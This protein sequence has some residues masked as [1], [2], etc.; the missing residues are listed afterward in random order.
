MTAQ[1]ATFPYPPF[2]HHPNFRGASEAATVLL[3]HLLPDHLSP[4]QSA[5][6]YPDYVLKPVRKG[7]LEAGINVIVPDKYGK[8]YRYLVAGQVKASRG[9]S[10]S[11]A[12]KEGAQ[13]MTLPNLDFVFSA[14]VALAADGRSLS[15]GYGF[16]VDKEPVDK[17]VD[18]LPR[19]TL[20][21]PLQIVELGDYDARVNLYATPEGVVIP[22]Q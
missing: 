3:E 18:K 6:C 13:L 1:V 12:Q 11:G 10:I 20:V 14:C 9:S 7:L 16:S 2:G 21:H 17:S 4:G 22:Q 8:G 5:L 19:A 15:K